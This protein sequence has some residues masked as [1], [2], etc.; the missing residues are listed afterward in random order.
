MTHS[1]IRHLADAIQTTFQLSQRMPGGKTWPS[2]E[3]WE[4]KLGPLWRKLGIKLG[5]CLRKAGRLALGPDVTIHQ[6]ADLLLIP[7]LCVVIRV[8]TQDQDTH[9]NMQQST[10][11]AQQKESHSILHQDLSQPM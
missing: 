7:L 8:T 3:S 9:K 1:Y 6:M 10:F 2:L 4:V 11:N 5:S